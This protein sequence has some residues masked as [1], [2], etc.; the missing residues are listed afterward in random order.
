MGVVDAFSDDAEDDHHQPIVNNY[1]IFRVELTRAIL[2]P[3]ESE[4][5]EYSKDR[6]SSSRESRTRDVYTTR[7]LIYMLVSQ[8]VNRRPSRYHCLLLLL[9]YF[10]SH[11]FQIL[12]QHGHL[13]MKGNTF[14]SRLTSQRALAPFNTIYQTTC[15]QRFPGLRYAS[16]E[17]GE[18]D[19]GH[20]SANKNQG[21][22]FINSELTFFASTVTSFIFFCDFRRR[23]HELRDIVEPRRQRYYH[24]FQ[25]ADKCLQRSDKAVL[26]LG[27]Q[28]RANADTAE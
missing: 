19:T 14:R 18:G 11:P 26:G 7:N 6:Q 15:T 23:T 4:S 16:L 3:N 5:K 24:C 1:S 25:H 21:V 8:L 2:T 17:A 28:T 12:N 13:I 27:A 9:V 20:I 22:L 10:W